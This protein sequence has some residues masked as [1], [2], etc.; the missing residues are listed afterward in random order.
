MGE[1][2]EFRV[3][4]REINALDASPEIKSHLLSLDRI[5]R[6]VPQI[7]TEE[8]YRDYAKRAEELWEKIDSTEVPVLTSSGGL[9]ASILDTRM[10]EWDERP[11]RKAN[12]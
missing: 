1:E 10:R 3:A 6:G 4:F 8:Q 9:L 5:D 2:D 12:E 11:K 7:K